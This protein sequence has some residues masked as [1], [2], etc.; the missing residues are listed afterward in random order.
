[1]STK[2]KQ[3]KRRA[4]AKSVVK[5]KNRLK[6]KPRPR[7]YLEADLPGGVGWKKVM[8]FRKMEDVDA[9]VESVEDIRRRNASEIVRGRVVM[10]STGRVVA[11]IEPHEIEGPEILGASGHVRGR[12]KKENAEGALE[13]EAEGV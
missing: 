4:R 11:V 2:R 8:A 1:M 6:A 12:G 3:D 7:F 9:Y 10:A 13:K 5:A